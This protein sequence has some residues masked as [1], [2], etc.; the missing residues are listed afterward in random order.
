MEW[1]VAVWRQKGNSF[2][3]GKWKE[4]GNILWVCVRIRN[5]KLQNISGKAE[6]VI[7][8]QE[9]LHIKKKLHKMLLCKSR[10]W[11]WCMLNIFGKVYLWCI[12]L[13]SFLCRLYAVPPKTPSKPE[14]QTVRHRRLLEL[15]AFSQDVIEDPMCWTF[16]NMWCIC[17]IFQV[18]VFDWFLFYFLSLVGSWQGFCRHLFILGRLAPYCDSTDGRNMELNKIANEKFNEHIIMAHVLKQGYDKF[19]PASR[20][21]AQSEAQTLFPTDGSAG[22]L[23]GCRILVAACANGGRLQWW[24]SAVAASDCRTL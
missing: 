2:R 13:T 24:S 6:L 14:S 11:M 4:M 3:I 10:P 19:P 22:L 12:C 21:L 7:Y 1:L 18:S 16:P 8:L 15:E 20:R 5:K 23:V 9:I 17:D